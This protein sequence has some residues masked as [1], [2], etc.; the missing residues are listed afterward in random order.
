MTIPSGESAATFWY[1]STAIGTITI[2]AAAP[3]YASASQQ[4]TITAAPA[5]LGIALAPG[6]T[7]SPVVSCGPPSASSTCNVSG[8]GAGGRVTLSVTFETAG[9]GPAVYSTTQASTIHETGQSAGS[10]TVGAGAAGSGPERAHRLVGHIDADVRP[11][12]P[13]RHRRRL[14]ATFR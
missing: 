10:V 4:E 5:G 13:R 2:G 3:G 6:S 8:V 11:L 1:G 12:L 9:Q 7:G 14:R